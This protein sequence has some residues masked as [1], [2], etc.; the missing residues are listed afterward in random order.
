MVVSYYVNKILFISSNILV[1]GVLKTP[2]SVAL[3]IDAAVPFALSETIAADIMARSSGT[4]MPF[5]VVSRVSE[6]YCLAAPD[7][8]VMTS[9]NAPRFSTTAFAGGP[10]LTMDPWLAAPEVVV[11]DGGRIAAVGARALL[12]AYPHARVEQLAGR[13]L[14]P[15]FID[16]HNHLSIAA[17]HPLWAD[18]S[19]VATVEQLQYALA[20]QAAREPAAQWIRGVGWNETTHG[21][22]LDRHQLDALGLDRPIIVVHFTLHQCVVSSRGLDELGIGRTTPDPQGGMIAHGSD[23][24]PSGLLIERAWSTAHAAS[25]AAYHDR[26]R[27]AELFAARAR[28]LLRDGITCVHDAACAPSAEAVYR[29][30]RAAQTLPISVLM[31]PHADAILTEPTHERLAGPPTGDGDEQ[32]RVGAVKLFADGGV[33]PAMDVSIAGQRS[34]F[35]IEFPGLVE[36]TTRAVA[37]GFRV[38]VHAIGNVGLAAALTACRE[39]ARLRRDDDH[40]FRIEHASLAARAQIAEMK[41]LGVVGVVQPGFLHHIGQAVEG[42]PFDEE[43]WLPFGDLARA[44]VPLAA[45]SDDP[46]AFHQ[47]LR[48]ASHGATR[49][50]GSGRILGPEQA[51]GY[52]EWL[53][54]YTAGAAYAGGQEHERGSLTPG[55]RADLVVLEGPLDPDHPPRVAQTWVAGE[56]VYAAA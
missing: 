22:V 41:A 29:I 47:P 5:N 44:G 34:Q 37:R 2:P 26:D 12:G 4:L 17:L 40:R 35:G 19:Q 52:E 54:L 55:K 49:R 45:S 51:I 27:W 15:G 13:T 23:G 48:T 16:A 56:L 7:S 36:A 38:A 28:Q 39:A 24:T 20:E 30:M 10:I 43:I 53:R 6:V 9:A 8:S 11:V 42:V 14:L 3:A 32:L 33:A 25:M 21:L 31:M 1:C 18:L 46:C 50:T